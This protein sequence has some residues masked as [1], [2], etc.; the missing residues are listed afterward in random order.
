MI[1]QFGIHRKR[2]G[3]RKKEKKLMEKWC[4]ATSR[5]DIDGQF[6]VTD[7]ANIFSGLSR[8]R[9]SFFFF[10]ELLPLTWTWSG[11]GI[12]A[13]K[14]DDGHD[15]AFLVSIP[16]LVH[17]YGMSKRLAWMSISRMTYARQLDVARTEMMKIEG[18]IRARCGESPRTSHPSFFC[19]FVKYP[20]ISNFVRV[21]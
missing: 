8:V 17:L 6:E 13:K 4:R 12:I 20:C 21:I 9:R 15:R 10:R 18:V 16:S 11:D 1:D 7:V 19:V 14:K 3:E 5:V 2:E